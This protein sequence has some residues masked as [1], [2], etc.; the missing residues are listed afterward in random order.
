MRSCIHDDA[1][2]GFDEIT[3]PDGYWVGCE[4]TLLL[5]GYCYYCYSQFHFLP[6]KIKYNVTIMLVQLTATLTGIHPKRAMIITARAIEQKHK[7]VLLA[8]LT[9]FIFI[10]PAIFPYLIMPLIQIMPDAQ[11]MIKAEKSG[12]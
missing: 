4:M 11:I 3:V 9:I 6:A 7:S 5:Y 8:S 2:I 10:F 12:T 1:S